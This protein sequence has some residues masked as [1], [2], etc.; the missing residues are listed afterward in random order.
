VTHQETQ[1]TAPRIGFDSQNDRYVLIEQE[2]IIAERA[3]LA[4][5]IHDGLAQI[6]GY[7]KM[8][9]SQMEAH[10]QA[11]E[12]AKLTQLI[13][14][15]HQAITEAFV[16]AREAIDDLRATAFVDDFSAWL[17]E[18]AENFQDGFGTRIEIIDFPEQ[19]VLPPETLNQLTRIIQEALSNIRKH[20]Q[21]ESVR[22]SFSQIDNELKILVEDNGIGFDTA[23]AKTHSQHGLRTMP[24]RAELMN[25]RLKIESQPGEG[26]LIE[27]A[28]PGNQTE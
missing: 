4:R 28:I 10:L 12:A 1:E 27:I 18:T 6:L 22:I 19:L 26:T 5:E 20:A 3:R 7:V 8:Q 21:A 24:E 17:Q 25:S 9:L 16:E 11:G 2:A 14:T 15:S 13:R 23:E